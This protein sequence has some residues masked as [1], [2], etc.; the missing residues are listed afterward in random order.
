ML[1]FVRRAHMRRVVNLEGACPFDPPDPWLPIQPALGGG[2]AASQP[3][4]PIIVHYYFNQPL[5][6]GLLPPK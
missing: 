1:S 6:V 5:A 4:P 2:C 3:N